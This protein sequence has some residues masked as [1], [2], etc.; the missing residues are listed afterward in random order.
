MNALIPKQLTAFEDELFEISTKINITALDL[1]RDLGALQMFKVSFAL[2]KPEEEL[3]KATEG[4][5]Q[6]TIEKVNQLQK[7]LT[8]FVNNITDSKKTS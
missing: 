6:I 3:I 4:M 5:K 8:E 2:T 7:Q 1:S